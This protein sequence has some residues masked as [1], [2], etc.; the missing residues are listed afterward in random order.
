MKNR[1]MTF[2]FSFEA[3]LKLNLIQVI[4]KGSGPS[5]RIIKEAG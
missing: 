4:I 2:D 1:C 3:L 5:E